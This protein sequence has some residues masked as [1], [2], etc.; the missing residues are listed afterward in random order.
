MMV[1]ECGEQ[2]WGVICEPM[3]KKRIEGAAK[4]GERVNGREA[5]VINVR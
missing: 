3:D 1:T 4:Q 2:P 5:L